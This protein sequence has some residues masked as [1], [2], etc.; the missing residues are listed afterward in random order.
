[1]KFV[2]GIILLALLFGP[3]AAMAQGTK[4]F[5]ATD[6]V[7]MK[8]L[9]DVQVS[10]DGRYA[11][12]TV[13]ETDLEEDKSQ[14]DIWLLDL[15]A[16]AK[17]PMRMTTHP[18]NDFNPRWGAEGNVLYFL[19]KRSGISEI[20]MIEIGGGEAQQLTD[21]PVD[22][23]MFEISK[24]GRMLVFS[25]FVYPQCDN[26]QCT[27]TRYH[28]IDEDPE[29]GLVYDKLMVRL[30]DAWRDGR[31]ARLFAL[32]LDSKG[33][34]SADEPAPL[35]GDLEASVPNY[36]LDGPETFEISPDGTRV[37]FSTQLRTADEPWSVNT[38]IYSARTDGLGAPENL[39]AANPA[40]DTQPTLS[41][42]G[43]YLAWLST[44]KPDSWSEGPKIKLKDLKTG[45]TRVL[46]PDWDRFPS[47]IDFGYEGKVLLAT[48]DHIGSR[49]LWQV[50]LSGGGPQILA[51]D[52][53]ISNVASSFRGTLFTKAD[54]KNPND[55]Y[56]QKGSQVFR[57]TQINKDHM[58][59]LKIGDYEQF[60]FTG[61]DGDTVYGYVVKPV[62]FMDGVKYPVAFLIHGGPLGSFTNTFHY[63]WNP[64]TY[65]GAGYAV[66]MIDFH[67]STG[68]GQ[69]FSDAIN[70]D[71]GGA[72][73]EDLKL[74]LRA[75]ARQFPWVD[76]AN[77]C[78]LGGSYGGYL[79]NLIEGLWQ[80]AFKCLV[81]HDGMF[82]NRMK[83]F[84][85]DLIGYLDEGFG[86]Q[87]YFED[88]TSHERFNPATLVDKWKTPILVIHGERDFRVPIT[89]GLG[90]FTAAQA[91]GIESKFLMFP[92]EN[93][94][95]I[96]PNNSIQWHREVNRWLDRWLK[97]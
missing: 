80:N 84:T 65:A 13:R 12:F 46:A 11:A 43:R 88:M 20:W 37:Y 45:E 27:A 24:N 83:Y 56:L 91:K 74:G 39:T 78:A 61:A 63:R 18:E 66:V 40:S 51:A 54:F 89:Q 29:K 70:N 73:I 15:A 67:G 93:H 62:D 90:A 33:R 69:A 53:F 95:V 30:W 28:I 60:S 85:S 48:A 4:P 94:W 59:T 87:P 47:T 55:L 23:D 76:A 3:I 36:P 38:D 22:V 97:P 14:T 75:A 92:N 42:D 26:L 1:M 10:P 81:T 64:Q 25:A 86:G 77:A 71:R 41:P 34:P 82:D 79:V 8:R 50:P 19:S 49:V 7:Q 9:Y 44:E 32:P 52:G 2:K 57:L 17:G 68:Y 16:I 31:M 5:S 58:D 35:M 21:Y 72:P 6:L 96:N